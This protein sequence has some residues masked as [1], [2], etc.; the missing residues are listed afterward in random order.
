MNG[1]SRTRIRINKTHGIARYQSG[2]WAVREVE[3]CDGS[4]A[5]RQQR[6]QDSSLAAAH[7]PSPAATDQLQ[8]VQLAL[9]KPRRQRAAADLQLG[10]AGRAQ[11][12]ADRPP[13]RGLQLVL[14]AAAAAAARRPGVMSRGAYDY[15]R[16]LWKDANGMLSC[17]VCFSEPPSGLSCLR[18]SEVSACRYRS[19]SAKLAAPVEPIS[20]FLRNSSPSQHPCMPF[21]QCH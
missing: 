6:A 10:Q 1:R 19:P 20:L 15:A 9:D 16:S 7:R 8:S 17:C 13:V 4:T 2:N 21:S 12:L 5:P 3:K 18:S 11:G 14:A